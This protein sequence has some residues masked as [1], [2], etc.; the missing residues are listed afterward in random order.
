MSRRSGKSKMRP[1]ADAFSSIAIW[2][3]MTFILLLCFVWVNEFFDLTA[4]VFDTEPE[5]FSPYRA[6]L[7]SAAIITAGVIAVGHTYEKQRSLVRKLLM[8]CLYCH[9]V[10]TDEGTWMHVEEYFLT[11]FP[12]EMERGACSDCEAMLKSVGEKTENLLNNA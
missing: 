4:K 12:V 3:F 7:M 5:P 6:F 11:H 2:Q 10:K 1:R 8:T 9:R